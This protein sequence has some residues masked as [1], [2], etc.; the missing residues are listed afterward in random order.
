MGQYARELPPKVSII[1]PVYNGG[2][3]LSEAIDSA[4]AQTYPAIEIIVVDDGSTDDGETRRIAERYGDKVRYIHQPNAGCGGAL[5]TGIGHMSGDYF[6]WLSHDDVYLPDKIARQIDVLASLEDKETILYSNYDTIDVKSRRLYSVEFDKLAPQEKLDLPLYGLTHGFV[7]GCTLLIA[8]TLFDKHGLFDPSLK[9]TQDYDLWFKMFRGNAVKFMPHRLVLSR[10]H[11]EQGS[12]KLSQALTEGD[13]LWTRFIEE[14]TPEEAT[15]MEGSHYRY[16]IGRAEFLKGTMY[17]AVAPIAAAKAERVLADTLVSVVIP[18]RNRVD[19]TIEALRSAQSQTHGNL[20]ILLVDDGS[21][22]DVSVL[23]D[24]AAEDRR[25]KLIRQEWA[26]AAAA[27]NRG[28]G[29]AQ[30]AYVAFL[31]SDDLW[32]PEKVARQLAFMEGRGLAISHTGYDR[33]SVKDGSTTPVANSYFAG[34]VY[35]QIISFCPIATPTVMVRADVMRSHPFPEKVFPG[36]DIVAWIAIARAHEIAAIDQPLTTVRVCE[37]TTSASI[38]K[39]RQGILNILTAVVAHPADSA[40]HR[41]IIALIDVLRRYEL[42]LA[43]SQPSPQVS[44]NGFRMPRHL[45]PPSDAA[46]A[47]QLF[48][49]GV[50]SLRRY[51]VR[52]TWG[53]VKGWR[54]ARAL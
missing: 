3:Y 19:M 50:D 24:I 6:S 7:H 52:A 14:V 29:V 31:D 53:R 18:L 12:R 15:Q 4:L 49:R 47:L 21:T 27:R 38:E 20:E 30:G 54:A 17:S 23:S 25:I 44:E 1:I 8:R 40:Q 13:A 41:E 33:L 16:L 5:N 36:E 11:P 9:A 26:G 34:N 37:D 28:V 46:V 10:V 2:N 43:K 32:A 22:D 39:S 45:R 35:P 51:G 48:S 42:Q